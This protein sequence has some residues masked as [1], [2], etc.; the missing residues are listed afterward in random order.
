[1][2]V[3]ACCMLA[4]SSVVQAQPTAEWPEVTKEMKPGSRWWWMGSAVDQENLRLCMQQYAEAGLGTLEI[5]PIYGVKGNDNKNISFLTPA[6][7]GMLDY[8]R[9]QG[10]QLGIDIDM[11]TGTGWPFG[12]PMLKT[13]ETA[14]SLATETLDVSGDGKTVKTI[15]INT[16]NG[17]LQRVLAYPQGDN[18]SDY[19]DLTGLL[20][21]KTVKW[22][23]PAGKWKVITV[24]CKH[25]IMQVKRASKG[26]EG[27]VLDHFD[28]DAVASYLSYFD[29]KFGAGGSPWPHSF[30][31]DSYEI[32]GGNWTR[33]MFEQFEKYRGY[34]L[35]SCMD[36][37]L[38]KDKQTLADYRQTLSDMLLH[39]FTEQWT[40]WAH[41]HGATTRNQAH[42]SPGNLIDLYAAADIPE[43]ES[44]Y[45]TDFDIRG[46]RKDPGFTM[47]AL[48]SWTTLKYASSAAH[49]TGKPLTSSES[50]TWLTEHFRSSLSQMKPEVDQLFAA[51]VNHVM[52]HGTCYSPQEAAWPG[53][54]FYASADISPTNSIWR[55]APAF[56]KYIER[57]QSFLQT[58]QPDNEVLVYAPFINAMHKNTGEFKDLFPYFNINTL[59][60]KMPDMVKCVTALRTAG[61]DCDYTSDRLLLGTTF[62]D[63]RLRTAAGV[64]YKSLV[65]PISTDMPSEVKE[66]LDRMAAQGANIIYGYADLTALGVQPEQMRQEG[67]SMIRR[68]DADGYHYFVAN[69][70]GNEHTGYF[71][72]AVPFATALLFDPMTGEIC[73]ARTSD[74]GKVWL[75][76]LSGQSVILRTYDTDTEVAGV[77]EW[78]DTRAQHPI[79]IEG[80]WKLTFTD[81]SYPA[82]AGKAYTLDRLQSW[83]TLDAETACLMGTGIYETTFDVTPLQMKAAS[84]GFRLHLGDVRESARVWVNGQYLGC[85]WSVPYILDCK[86][87]VKEG[88][89]TLRIEVTNLPANRIRKMDADGV[90]WRI[91]EDINMS[92]ISSAS[93]ATWNLVPSGLN[94]YVQL[95]PLSAA[96]S[97]LEATLVKIRHDDD[98]N[99]YPVYHVRMPDGATV[100]S[101]SATTLG[102]KPFAEIET[103]KQD[104]GSID[105]VVKGSSADDIVLTA[106]VE[107]ED[108]YTTVPAY[109]AFSVSQAIDFTAETAPGGGWDKM[110]TTI[111]MQ[112][113]G[114]NGKQSWYRSKLY[115]KVLTD[116]YPGMTFESQSSNYYFYFP[117]YGMNANNNFTVSL[118]PV[119]GA[120]VRLS[121]MKGEGE[122]VYHAA[123]SLVSFRQC[124]DDQ[125]GIML[126]MPNNK[127]YYIY[128]S[129]YV[130]EPQ[131]ST[132]GLQS[133]ARWSEDHAPYYNLYGIQ[134][135][136]P[137]RGLYI[138][139]GKKVVVR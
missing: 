34:K 3:T 9:Q 24:Y 105:V 72:L 92:N 76:L 96:A 74:D 79:T 7:L 33:Y 39:N 85:A 83:E 78:H 89:N 37:L 122:S 124:V 29:A 57:V 134:V 12:G 42:G 128:R 15:T 36:K 80:P 32:S 125:E 62:E 47:K 111:V 1:M 117:G 16:G 116:L 23:A 75:N 137:R 65:V 120:I 126:E 66:H 31:N 129:L 59:D 104:D 94:S 102:N 17:T 82:M 52:F 123:D 43:T 98:G 49:V 138:H 26:G 88:T 132:A 90:E 21:G 103:I 97:A 118:E 14:A 28:A 44:F 100:T 135:N 13:A 113:F 56:F 10:Q 133:V 45:L 41:S 101:V 25:Q 109:G 48:S 81:D 58:G 77:D 11:T 68:K 70:T 136:R 112:G 50:M 73:K 91:F 86:N 30:F 114:G 121:Y 131:N 22:T 61:F 46:L 5:T 54:K 38:N 27:Y 63:G 53:W 93:Y 18:T 20:E 40:A 4:V 8:T 64:A 139:R 19:L 99:C 130:Y 67:L 127:Q 69:L 108:H 95:V 110:S 6:W 35:E 115:G 84:G 51:G 60:A 2:T 87:V 55:D 106:S 71:R 107:G 119:A